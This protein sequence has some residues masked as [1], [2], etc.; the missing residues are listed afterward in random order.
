MQTVLFV[1]LDKWSDWEMGP[2][3]A[4]I[5]MLGQGAYQNRI[6][7]LTATPVESIGGL[8]VLPD[9]TVQSVPADYA[10]M[11]L[12]GGLSWRGDAAQAVGELA[13][14]SMMESKVLGAICDASGFL[15]TQ[16][17]LNN[18]CHTGND[19]ADMQAWAG[20]AYTGAAQFVCEPSVCDKSIVTANGTA[21]F[22]FARD[23]LLA[24]KIAPKEKVEQWYQ[25][26]KRGCYEAPM[27]VF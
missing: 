3:A 5:H 24:L 6:V 18:V 1:L 12:V 23:M 15:A 22:E 9:Y 13:R 26:C 10:A 16:G 21:P 17:L 2:V 25:F 11:V 4:A 19:L 14:K 8:R 27:P 7:A 20:A